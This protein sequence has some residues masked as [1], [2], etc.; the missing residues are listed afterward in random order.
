[1]LS[2]RYFFKKSCNDDEERATMVVLDSDLGA[3]AP[4][5]AARTVIISTATS[6]DHGASIQ[7]D[8]EADRQARGERANDSC[9]WAH[10]ETGERQGENRSRCVALFWFRVDSIVSAFD[11]EC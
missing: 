2:V 1:M 9:G 5:S 10:R 8:R 4:D 3:W 7:R 6:P 11:W